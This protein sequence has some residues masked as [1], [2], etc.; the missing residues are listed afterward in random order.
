VSRAT[1]GNYK[2]LLQEQ[3]KRYCMISCLEWVPQGAADPTPKRYELSPAEIELLEKQAEMK[4]TVDDSDGDSDGDSDHDKAELGVQFP[5]IDPKSLPADLKMDE[6]SDDDENND[7]IQGSHVGNLLVGKD[8]DE[9]E[10]LRLE[11]QFNNSDSDNESGNDSDD[12]LADVPDTREY[13]PVDVEG[14]ESMGFHSGALNDFEGDDIDNASDVD[15]INLN[16]DDAMLC[17]A[18]TEEDFASLEIHVYEQSSGNL[19]VHH[20]IPLPSFP[21][22]LAHGDIN[23]DGGAGNY[24]AVGTFS[25]GIE[26]WNLLKINMMRAASGK[27]LKKKKIRKVNGLRPGSHTDAVMAL[28][29]NKF[30]RQV[31]ASGS[32]DCTVKLWDITQAK[33]GNACSTTLTHHKD[34]V[35]SLAWHPT[36]GTL[37]ATGSFDRF[38]ALLDARSPES[39][40]HTK[41]VKLSADCEAI[42][43]DPFHTH[44][45]TAA[46]ED[47]T[48]ACWDVRKFDSCSPLWSFVANEYGGVSDLSYSLEVPGMMVTCA[49]DKSVSLW[50]TQHCNTIVEGHKSVLLP[51]LCG[52][53]DMGVGK[54][55]TVSFYPSF[56]WLLGSG[57]AGNELALWDLRDELSVQARF[58]SRVKNNNNLNMECSQ[59]MKATA[60]NKGMH[61]TE[62]KEQNFEAMMATGDA[63]EEKGRRKNN[64]RSEG[65]TLKK[66]KVHRRGK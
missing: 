11:A 63:A 22:C 15:D 8:Y 34:K 58:G 38:V 64:K 65:K 35:Q 53:K 42:A 44:C 61:G 4:S 20:D 46:S 52:N 2:L 36:E 9:E 62:Q 50:D 55:Y 26:V 48:I 39:H 57:G 21:L 33:S 30:H 17:V 66:E 51:Q 28:A 23:A 31:I 37:L 60:A 1:G 45:L 10:D 19:F 12:D 54:L 43:W 47:G 7:A 16:P 49:I 24:C 5:P 56:P 41:K 32:A 25:P 6:Y 27:K 13:M 18:K 3:L 29:W 14:L 59:T 40:E